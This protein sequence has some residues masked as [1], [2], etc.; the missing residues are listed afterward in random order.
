MRTI[1]FPKNSLVIGKAGGVIWPQKLTVFHLFR[2]HFP[3]LP[4]YSVTIQSFSQ[5]FLFQMAQQKLCRMF[6]NITGYNK[7]NFESVVTA[8]LSQ[9]SSNT[10]FITIFF[11]STTVFSKSPP[12]HTNAQTLAACFFQLIIKNRVLLFF[13]VSLPPY[14]S[15][16]LTVIQ[17][18]CD[19]IILKHLILKT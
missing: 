18:S 7:Q 12:T 9:S 8:Y 6:L 13:Q 17:L 11:F 5:Y 2:A 4:L 3:L 14:F 19:L 15:N 16:L 1:S 10:G